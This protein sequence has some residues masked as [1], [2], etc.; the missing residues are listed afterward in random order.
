MPSR[1]YRRA[2][3]TNYA[4]IANR[5]IIS[6]SITNINIS[7]KPI[8]PKIEFDPTQPPPTDS[9]L[10]IPYLQEYIFNI[11]EIITTQFDL[12]LIAERVHIIT[13]TLESRNK[14]AELLDTI[15]KSVCGIVQN[16]A[17]GT[18]MNIIM[19]RI[20]YIRGLFTDLPEC[21]DNYGDIPELLFELIDSISKGLDI[22]TVTTNFNMITNTLRAQED[23]NAPLFEEIQ[24]V[25]ISIVDNIANGT[26]PNIITARLQ[27]LQ[28]LISKI[29]CPVL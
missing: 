5:P 6:Q 4:R 13:S 27:Y 26:S 21:V 1:H 18:S 28:S 8:P 2:I 11:I 12:T 23:P 24:D 16:I 19:T 22:D 20:Q 17:D 3:R 10:L 15:E 25:I 9:S 14:I 7:L 29:Q